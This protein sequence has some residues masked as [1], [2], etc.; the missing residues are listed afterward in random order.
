MSAISFSIGTKGYVGTGMIG[1]ESNLLGTN[2]FWEYDPLSDTIVGIDE[3]II[4]AINMNCYPNPSNGAFVIEIN[5]IANYS[6][7]V[8]DPSGNIVYEMVGVRQ[9]TFPVDLGMLRNGIYFVSLKCNHKQSI[10][11]INM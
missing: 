8:F 6:V 11:K 4:S 7:D 2:D 3:I 5:K 9:K 10:Q 1:S